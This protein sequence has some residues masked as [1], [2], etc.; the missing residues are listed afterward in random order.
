MKVFKSNFMQLLLR[1]KLYVVESLIGV[2][3][4][5]EIAGSFVEK[6]KKLPIFK[7]KKKPIIGLLS[8]CIYRALAKPIIRLRSACIYRAVEQ[9]HIIRCLDMI[10]RLDS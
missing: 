7:K 9:D 5:P 8:A 6:K 10:H 2:L 3:L 4:H 1:T